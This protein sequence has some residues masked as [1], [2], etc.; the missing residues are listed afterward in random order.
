M[1]H[2]L[3]D[4][5]KNIRF[6]YSS[7]G[8]IDLKEYVLDNDFL[9]T[10]LFSIF[11]IFESTDITELIEIY[12][13]IEEIEKRKTLFLIITN[14]NTFH[15]SMFNFLN[16]L[17]NNFDVDLY[18]K[19]NIVF[20]PN[21]QKNIIN[22]HE[23]IYD[24]ENNNYPNRNTVILD[25]KKNM[26]V[27]YKEHYIKYYGRSVKNLIRIVDR[28]S[29]VNSNIDI[30]LPACWDGQNQLSK[31]D[32][33]S[34]II[35]KEKYD[36]NV[37]VVNK[38]VN[39]IFNRII[40]NGKNIPLTD[41]DKTHMVYECYDWKVPSSDSSDNSNKE[42][43][44]GDLNK[45]YNQNI[46]NPTSNLGPSIDDDEINNINDSN[47][48]NSNITDNDILDINNP[49]NYLPEKETIVEQIDVEN[50]ISVDKGLVYLSS[51]LICDYKNDNYITELPFKP[52]IYAFDND[53]YE[54]YEEY[55]W[56]DVITKIESC[57]DLKSKFSTLYNRKDLSSINSNRKGIGSIYVPDGY[58]L[59]LYS[60]KNMDK[61]GKIVK[62][63]GPQVFISTNYMY[64]ANICWNADITY[65]DF[66]QF[67]GSY[68]LF[69]TDSIRDKFNDRLI[70]TKFINSKDFNVIT[71]NTDN[72]DQTT[73]TLNKNGHTKLWFTDGYIGNRKGSISGAGIYPP[74]IKG[75][76]NTGCQSREVGDYPDME[77]ALGETINPDP[78]VK[79][80]H[81]KSWDGAYIPK[82]YQ[83]TL[84]SEKNFK[85]DSITYKAIDDDIYLCT[86]LG[87]SNY[88]PY[89]RGIDVKKLDAKKYTKGS[90]RYKKLSYD[91]DELKITDT[92]D[93]NHIKNNEYYYDESGN[94][95]NKPIYSTKDENLTISKLGVY[96][97]STDLVEKTPDEILRYAIDD[98]TGMVNIIQINKEESKLQKNNQM[99]C[100]LFIYDKKEYKIDTFETL[101]IN[102]AIVD[103]DLLGFTN[104][105]N[106]LNID[107]LTKVRNILYN[108]QN[109]ILKENKFF[110]SFT[111][112]KY[113]ITYYNCFGDNVEVL[114][115]ELNIDDNIILSPHPLSTSIDFDLYDKSTTEINKKDILNSN[116]IF[117]GIKKLNSIYGYQD[118]KNSNYKIPF[119]I[120]HNKFINENILQSNS[121]NNDFDK[122][123]NEPE[124]LFYLS[125]FH[126]GYYH[127][128]IN[129]ND[130]VVKN[131][132]LNN[133]YKNKPFNSGL[134]DT[135]YSLDIKGFYHFYFMISID[136]TWDLKYPYLYKNTTTKYN[137]NT[138]KLTSNIDDL[139]LKNLENNIRYYSSNTKMLKSTMNQNE[140]NQMINE[141][142]YYF[143]QDYLTR[144][145]QEYANIEVKMDG[146][147]EVTKK[148]KT[149]NNG[150]VIDSNI[151][152]NNDDL[153][154][155]YKCVIKYNNKYYEIIRATYDN[156]KK[157]NTSNNQDKTL[158][159]GGSYELSWG[160]V[161]KYTIKKGEE[162]DG[163][164][165]DKEGNI[166]SE[167]QVKEEG[168]F[169]E[170][171]DLD[172][173][174]G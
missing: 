116:I 149:D 52:N 80:Y 102:F 35:G 168:K 51:F 162:S 65:I 164:Y 7:R 56:W 31:K 49:E 166:I 148:I 156:T 91:A 137:C 63:I 21:V 74:Y 114:N 42:N 106:N 163:A 34:L 39:S 128:P 150:F 145:V 6:E 165:I 46:N 86:G 15:D 14:T 112:I 72:N 87:R 90:C 59:V 11:N 146:N 40:S 121:S 67:D 142:S 30:A 110:N 44:T 123:E 64:D 2:K 24:N 98:K 95:I 154:N 22:T 78:Y 173:I 41:L 19:D 169:A 140:K 174:F 159:I 68:N 160:S 131:C 76:H 92:D 13:Y 158:K 18:E 101:Y 143:A 94:K 81:G 134:T 139:L 32:V 9:Y 25:N 88:E 120:Q 43:I 1:S 61:S 29:M 100:K 83:L 93:W 161:D 135:N 71:G 38:Y 33:D 77:I 136:N 118:S 171:K 12:K 4:E 62:L 60:K 96:E 122:K 133:S 82:G 172:K 48:P 69:M 119:I 141:L 26:K 153:N 8:P 170:L 97:V 70:G 107:Y 130:I 37:E 126:N 50:N 108:L 85:G 144:R 54:I 111:K 47:V 105:T 20:L 103:S 45:W 155:I 58:T 84:Y 16:M 79:G 27:R 109:I 147:E 73:S 104:T 89:T 152:L 10:I 127:F 53:N 138:S 113:K 57:K 28:I 151:K 3:W 75:K 5:I 115:D 167:P 129:P 23:F 157:N 124:I 66:E 17:K 36:F 132:L 117:N 99:D 125:K 55:K